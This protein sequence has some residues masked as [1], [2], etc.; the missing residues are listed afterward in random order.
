[1]YHCNFWG[2]FGC[3]QV[4]KISELVPGEALAQDPW[5]SSA[6]GEYVLLDLTEKSAAQYRSLRVRPAPSKADPQ[7][8]E[9]Q[10]DAFS[11]RG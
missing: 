5:G 6:R 8:T 9:P 10:K 4:G 7:K 2:L 1:V 11:S 3:V